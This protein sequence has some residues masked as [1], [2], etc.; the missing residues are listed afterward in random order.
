MWTI[1]KVGRAATLIVYYWHDKITHLNVKLLK[2]ARARAL[3]SSCGGQYSMSTSYSLIKLKFDAYGR[4]L[5]SPFALTSPAWAISYFLR[6]L[7]AFC[8]FVCFGK[9]IGS[10]VVQ[11][12]KLFYSSQ[13]ISMHLVILSC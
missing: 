13:P 8:H 5:F 4:I 1:A 6:V 9:I 12:M 11:L 7:V 3:S 10:T 2:S